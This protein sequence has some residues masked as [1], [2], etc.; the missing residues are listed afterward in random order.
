[1]EYV[2][3]L[4]AATFERAGNLPADAAEQKTPSGEWS[5]VDQ[6]RHVLFAEGLW[7][8]WRGFGD[9]SPFHPLSLP[10]TFMDDFLGQFGITAA[11]R[12]TLDEAR[13]ALSATAVAIRAH[14]A[15]LTDEALAQQATGVGDEDI[16]VARALTVYV[17][18]EWEHHHSM[19]Q[20]MDELEGS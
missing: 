16:S 2:H 11:D 9:E 5:I 18:H 8:N 7:A 3:G 15:A 14:F 12:C 20:L 10:P 1:M 17:E 19:R 4:R 13:E 6:L